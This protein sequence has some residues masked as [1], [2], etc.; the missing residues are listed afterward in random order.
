M[1]R[2]EWGWWKAMA[3]KYINRTISR[4]YRYNQRFFARKL[5]EY[6][7]PL[8]VGQLPIMIQIYRQPGI[9]QD[10]ISANAGMDKGTVAHIVKDLE[11]AGLIIRRTDP[12]DRRINH[13]SATEKGLSYEKPLFDII[14]ELHEVLYQGFCSE[15]IEEA[16]SILEC[17]KNNMRDYLE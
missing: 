16:I 5:E 3:E 14:R 4:M 6:S 8:E 17:M 10:G 2:K 7:L 11:K 12:D 1:S 9:T 15:K 13:I